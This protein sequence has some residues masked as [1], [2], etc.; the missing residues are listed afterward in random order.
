ITQKAR[1]EIIDSVVKPVISSDL[2]DAKTKYFVNATGKFVIGG[3]QSDTGM[4]GRK[5]IVDTYGGTVPHGG[6][7]FSGKDPTKVDRSATYAARY[8]AKNI[9]AAGLAER[10]LIQLAYVIGVADPVSIM[11]NSFGTL[12]IPHARLDELIRK[13]FALTPRGIIEMLDLRRPIYRNTAAY[14]HFGRTEP[15]FTWEKTDK[16]NDLKRDV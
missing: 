14:G 7:A 4:T 3:P 15:T 12:K 5:I 6:G 1:N 8:I 9:V 11:I 16:A 13:H 2:L 10:L